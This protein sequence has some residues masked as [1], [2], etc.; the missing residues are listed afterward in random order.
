MNNVKKHSIV[1]VF[2][3]NYVHPLDNSADCEKFV[4]VSAHN[5]WFLLKARGP[6]VSKGPTKRI[7]REWQR[8]F[9]HMTNG[10]HNYTSTYLIAG[11]NFAMYFLITRANKWIRSDRFCIRIKVKRVKKFLNLNSTYLLNELKHFDLNLTHL[12][13]ELTHL[14]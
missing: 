11:F 7:H 9:L 4:F 13:N 14:K 6:N 10:L 8:A 3:H 1:F 12:L 5:V 2:D